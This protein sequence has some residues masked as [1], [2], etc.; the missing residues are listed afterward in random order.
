MTIDDICSFIFGS[1][2]VSE[3]FLPKKKNFFECTTRVVRLL[4]YREIFEFKNDAVMYAM[5]LMCI[6]FR[7]K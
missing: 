1:L 5:H 4:Y 7:R 3:E 6:I 2:F